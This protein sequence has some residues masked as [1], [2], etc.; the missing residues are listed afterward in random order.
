MKH[1]NAY[2]IA[3]AAAEEVEQVWG[4]SDVGLTI[5][6]VAERI[7]RPATYREALALAARVHTGRLTVDLSGIFGV[8][9]PRGCGFINHAYIE[10]VGS[11]RDEFTRVPCDRDPSPTPEETGIWPL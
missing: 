4:R 5:A 7:G 2:W 8:Y 3:L 11:D 10:R 1:S 6:Q 9:L